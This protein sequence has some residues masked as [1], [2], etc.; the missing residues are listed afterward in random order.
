MRKHL[1]LL[2]LLALAGRAAFA[3]SIR[4]MDTIVANTVQGFVKEHDGIAVSAAVVKDGKLDIYHYGTINQEKEQ[5]PVNQTIYE[6]GSITKTFESIILAHAVLE[7]RVKL[8]DDIRKYLP[9]NYP[10]LEYAGKPIQLLHLVNLTSH[11]PNNMPDN[12]EAFKGVSEDSIPYIF[13]NQLKD[14][15][16][17]KF[18]QDLYKVKLDTVPGLIPRHSNAAALLLTYILGNIYNKPFEQLLKQ[19]ITGPIHMNHTY[20]LLP[21]DKASQLLTAYNNKGMAMPYVP[22]NS[23]MIKSSVGDMAKY[24]QYQLEEK[25]PAVKMTHEAYWG[26][27]TTFAIGMNWF[28]GKSADGKRKIRDDGTTFGFTTYILLYP[29]HRFG[30]TLMSNECDQKSND[31]LGKMADRIFNENFYT[32]EQI[33][34]DGFGYS[35]AINKLLSGLEQKGFDHAIEVADELKKSGLAFKLDEAEINNWGYFL[36]GKGKTD[37]ALDI[38]KLNIHLYPNSWNTYDSYGETLLKVNR[39]D[40][41]IQMYKKSIQ[42]NP[43]NENGKKVLADLGQK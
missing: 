12:P 22:D 41:A 6:I 34:S 8:D 40:E 28:L 24:M 33:A 5:L 9:G 31:R 2:A 36:L 42:L 38:F 14:Y 43:N 39:R 26:D 25:D 29:E 37:K 23:V 30:I 21:K 10:N 32:P 16:K 20:I 7:K 3:Q 17:E 1:L 19:Y 27:V 11:L 13:V 18:L 15:T 4:K 35:L